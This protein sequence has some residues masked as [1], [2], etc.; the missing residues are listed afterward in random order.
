MEG[1]GSRDL[2][3]AG[4]VA[5][6]LLE[7][8][9][10]GQDSAGLWS[11]CLPGNRVKPCAEAGRLQTTDTRQR[12]K[13]WL[14]VSLG[15]PGLSPNVAKSRGAFLTTQTCTLSLHYHRIPTAAML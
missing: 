11:G 12:R 3:G 2:A 4:V 1:R 15:W 9:G 7:S 10:D 13:S 8:G 14:E 6:A 5:A